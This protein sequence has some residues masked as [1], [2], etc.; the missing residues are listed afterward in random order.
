MV[1]NLHSRIVLY[2]FIKITIQKRFCCAILLHIDAHCLAFISLEQI[3]HSKRR[4][5]MPVTIRDVAARAQVS[6][7]TVS[8]TIRNSPSISKRTQDRVR[9]AMAELGYEP[10]VVAEAV[11]H[12]KGLSILGVI[13][14]P[15][16]HSAYENPF[17][18]EV[19]RG[20]SQFANMR[21]CLSVT[22]TGKDD[23]EIIHAIKNLEKADFACS[24]IALFA[25]KN[26]PVIQYLYDQGIDYVQIGQPIIHKSE[27]VCVDNDNI[28]AGYDATAHLAHLGHEKIAFVGAPSSQLFSAAR[29]RGYRMYLSEHN[30]PTIPE[31]SFEIEQIEEA[32]D[33][34]RNLLDPSNP[35]LPT[36]I[37]V[38]DDL[39]G[40]IVRQVCA[41]QGISIPDD[42]SI[43]SFNNSIFSKLNSPFISSIDVNAIQLG[44]EAASQAL[45]HLENPRLMASRTLVPYQIINRE[46]CCPPKDKTNK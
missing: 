17:F 19:I 5:I 4:H 40:I 45:N 18:L 34:I 1:K 22:I 35:D 32:M 11:E 21:H 16:D 37:V 39:F 30:L 27:T 28:Q 15:S 14:P 9:K 10:P 43:I 24:F 7:S 3:R 29:R 23:P 42:L 2:Y 8:R 20:I 13:L 31:L 26:D 44:V 25:R 33:Q 41:E 12:Q 46:S 6:P 38:S 36:A